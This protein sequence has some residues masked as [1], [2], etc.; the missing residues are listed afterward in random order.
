M[1]IIKHKKMIIICAIVVF[2]VILEFTGTLPYII[3]RTVTSAYIAKEYPTM[4]LSFDY[5]D[6]SR[7]PVFGDS[8]SVFYRD[9][10][11]NNHAFVMY[12]KRFPIYVL[13]DSIKGQG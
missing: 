7:N 11:G 9:K 13:F 8:Y 3:A 1:K 10:D 2:L 12:P 4:E 6:G 5:T